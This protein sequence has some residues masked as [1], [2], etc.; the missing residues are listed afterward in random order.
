MSLAD[1]RIIAL[2]GMPGS[3]KSSCVQFLEQQGWPNVYFGGVIV[4]EVRARGQEV[5]E[6]NERVVREELRAK[7]G[8]GAV[9]MRIIP[10][11]DAFID[12]GHRAIIAD[13][14]YG[15][16][17]YKIL[18]QKY[19]HSLIIIAI[20]APRSL[21]HERL[22]K[23]PVRPLTE[24]QADSRDRAEIERSEKGG[25]IAYADYTIVNDATP[26]DM[27]NKLASILKKEEIL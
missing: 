19:G 16:T 18:E 24:E 6:A 25:P 11:I 10:K 22:T 21:R 9:A 17:E 23:R 20:T 1:A 26:E 7:D 2:V 13:G 8:L 14:L 3:G 12:A 15:W 5:N 27:M 4:D